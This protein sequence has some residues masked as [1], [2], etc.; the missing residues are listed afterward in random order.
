M[1][2][3]QIFILR[4]VVGGI[5]AVVLTKIF[6]PQAGLPAMVGLTVILVGLAYVFEFFR[7]KKP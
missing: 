2:Q 1:N 7:K 5:F 4:A 3:I 6:R